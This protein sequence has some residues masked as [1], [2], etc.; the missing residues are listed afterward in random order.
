MAVPAAP[1]GLTENNAGAL[2][3]LFGLSTG[4]IF[5]VLVLAPIQALGFT[6]DSLSFS[7][8]NGSWDGSL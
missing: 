6:R 1:A 7:I 8:W 3:Y 2:C 5:P 4:I